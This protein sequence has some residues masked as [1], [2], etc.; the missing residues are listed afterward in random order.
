MSST[1]KIW[2]DMVN[3]LDGG[4]S[5]K[6]HSIACTPLHSRALHTY[7]YGPFGS[8]VISNLR[9]CRGVNLFGIAGG[10]YIL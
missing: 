5:A 8:S 4:S 9:H 6:L 7:S 1:G 2:Q 10:R 3:D